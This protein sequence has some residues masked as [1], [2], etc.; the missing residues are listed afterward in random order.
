MRTRRHVKVLGLVGALLGCGFLASAN[1]AQPMPDTIP[2]KTS[3]ADEYAP[4]SQG[5]WLSWTQASH[6]HPNHPAVFVQSGSGPKIRVNA[7][8]TNGE[9]SSID[10]QTLVY[11]EWKGDYA[12]DIR[13]FDLRTHRRSNFPAKVSTVWDEYE[14]TISGPWLLFTRYFDSTQTTKVLLYNMQT[15]ALR[16][17]GTDKGR[18]RWVYSGQVN[19]DYAAWGRI[20][21]SGQDDVYLYRISTKTNT[22]I[23]RVGFSQYNP[24]VTSDG[25]IYYGRSGNACGKTVSLVRYA[26][27]GVTTVLHDYPAGT[28]VGY[29]YADEQT[30]GSLQVLYN[31]LSCRTH[32]SDIYKVIDSYTYSISKAGSGTGTVTSDPAG[33]DCGTACQSVF[34][35]GLLVTLTATPAAGS[36]F[37]GW[38]DP[39]CGMR[40]TCGLRLESD[41]S[42]TASFDASS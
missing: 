24:S 18:H 27:G 8:G 20:R 11:Y 31:Q 36:V 6:A 39:S 12:G 41:F 14:P 40:T 13:K 32:R 38:S 30:D 42:L 5:A 37:S 33:I 22:T 17:L 35:G 25:T 19:G 23:P 29:I 2:V 1:A 15:H 10:G 9:E 34:H 3:S 7:P 28:D 16:T 4:S 26:P 21:P